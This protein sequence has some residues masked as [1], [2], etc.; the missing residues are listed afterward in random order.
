MEDNISK[1]PEGWIKVKSKSRPDKEYFHNKSLNLSLWRIEDLSKFIDTKSKQMPTKSIS[2]KKSS[3]I[4]NASKSIK[5]DN[6]RKVNGAKD[7]MTK[8]KVAINEERGNL[9]ITKPYKPSSP[10]KN[11]E[12]K[13]LKNKNIALKRITELS[14]KL[15]KEVEE[16]DTTNHTSTVVTEINND[17]KDKSSD[18]MMDVS[19][20]MPSDYEPMEWETIPEHEVIN[21][22]Q[23]IRTIAITH[24]ERNRHVSTSRN[25]K[26]LDNLFHIVV[27]TNV[28]LSN[29]DYVKLIKGKMFKDIGRAIIF[30]P[31][32]VLCELDKLKTHE[33][34]V[35]KLARRSISFIDDSF[36]SKDHFIHGQSA[37]ESM[38]KQLIPID[39]GDDE[40]LNSCL[41]IQGRT[42]KLILL[43]NDKNLRNKAFVNNIESFSKE[44]LNFTDFNIK[45][46]I[47]FD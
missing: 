33:D 47:K 19:Y 38:E 39:C 29:L 45:N 40:I 25:A 28:L 18:E 44:M 21:E 43:T 32:I 41:H 46:D 4:S 35:A 24:E 7:R 1:L 30:L 13:K 5:K 27:D 31:Y 8:L 9:N 2:P 34:N 26:N 11:P 12:G 22:V 20:E 3:S 23:K 15:K 42:K 14:E 36:S 17:N 16:A 6:I 37:I 10:K